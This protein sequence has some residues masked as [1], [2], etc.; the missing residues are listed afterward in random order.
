MR[1]KLVTSSKWKMSRKRD[2]F[3]K[4]FT[5]FCLSWKVTDPKQRKPEQLEGYNLTDSA[6]VNVEEGE[7]KELKGSANIPPVQN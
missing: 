2:L 3:V 1:N 6:S 5:L 4:R 7:I